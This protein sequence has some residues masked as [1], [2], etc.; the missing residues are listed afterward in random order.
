[1]RVQGA[2]KPLLLVKNLVPLLALELIHPDVQKLLLLDNALLGILRVETQRR[3]VV[4]RNLR[5]VVD[6]LHL[7]LVPGDVDPGSLGRIPESASGP[8]NSIRFR[9]H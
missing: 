7:A 6:P 3:L 4:E 1:M 8:R 2:S 9:V 5:G